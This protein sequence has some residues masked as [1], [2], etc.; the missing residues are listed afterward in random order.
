MN[1]SRTLSV[2]FCLTTAVLPAAEPV[3]PAEREFFEKSV[4]PVLATHCYQC[5]GPKKQ[6]AELRLDSR[7]GMLKGG[8][9]GPAITPGKPED[10]E[11][12]LA[13][14]Y[15]PSGYQMPPTGKLKPDEIEALTRWVKMGAPW[16]GDAETPA[17]G[18]E[19]EG[20]DIAERARHWSFQPVRRPEVPAVD[21]TSWPRNPIDQFLLARLEA[22]S[23]QPADPAGKRTWLRRVTFDLTGLPPTPEE[24][25]RFLEDHSPEAHEKVVDRLLTSPAYGERWARHWLDLVR[26]AE[27]SGHEFDYDIEYSRPYRDYVVR[28]LNADVPYN[29]F[30]IEHIAGDLLPDP[31]RHPL[32]GTNESIIG[33]GFYWFGQGKHS[34]VD[35]A[36]EE[37]D[38][39][40]N[41]LDVLGKTFLGLTIACA[42]CHDH[43]FDPITARDYYAMS[44][45]LQSSRRQHAYIDPPERTKPLLQQLADVQEQRSRLLS[46]ILAREIKD[47]DAVLDAANESAA[48]DLHHPLHAW[49]V[50]SRIDSESEFLAAKNQLIEK[51]S[52]LATPDSV[53]VFA[54]FSA[55]SLKQWRRTGDAFSEAFSPASEPAADA[56]I[57]KLSLPMTANSGTL[58]GRLQGEL[59]SP[60]FAIAKRY[61]DYR[62][63]RIGGRPNPGRPTKNGQVHLIVDGFQFIKDPLYGQLTINIPPNEPFRW[64][65]QDL[66]KFQGKNAYIEIED[67]EDGAVI[68]DRI[69][70]SDA[71]PPPEQA[72]GLV[73]SLLKDPGLTNPDELRTGYANLFRESV[74]HWQEDRLGNDDRS[75]SRVELLNAVLTAISIRERMTAEE[76]SEFESLTNKLAKRNAEIPEP[77]R[78][79]AMADGTG[80]EARVLIRG[81]PSKPGD[82]VSRRF[83]EVFHDPE[84][85]LPAQ[86]S[87][88]LELARQIADGENPLTA[89]VLVNRLWLHHFGRGLVATPDDF[90]KMGEAPSHPELL[91][92]L[93]SEF[94][95]NGWSLKHMHRLMVL[96]Q[97]YRMVS[98]AHAGDEADPKNLLLHRMPVRRLEAE[99]IRDAVLAVS[100]RLDRRMEGPSVLPHLTPFMEGRG[101]PG[102]SGPLDGDGRRSLYI[103]VRRNFLT[104]MFLAFDYP[105]PFTTMGRRSVSNVPAQALTM[106]NNPFIIQQARVWADRVLA[107]KHSD[108]ESRIQRLYEMAYTRP[109]TEAEVKSAVEFLKIQGQEYNGPEDPRTWADLCHVLMNV[110]E[111]LFVN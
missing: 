100:G 78:A 9:T 16:P 55:E 23:L 86:G 54:D 10:S 81:N 14:S 39:I 43:K 58:A 102:R 12:V 17:A 74:K 110:K 71:G 60:T 41:Q 36:A 40:D 85:S 97:T 19:S 64:Y 87:G 98:R 35:L 61:I 108:A 92:W 65:R 79:I 37:C 62:M 109:P 24:A 18:G 103:N 11:L 75:R 32:T 47:L 7:A 104:P 45:F 63:R 33:T 68:V 28:A 80:E 107:E 84:H 29:Q 52:A 94:V 51:L 67:E 27:T 69:V 93:A 38:S 44:G 22:A 76:R 3:T 111:F 34:P 56:G 8:Q 82:K 31:R 53:E 101:R 2:F 70:F 89:R 5:H 4:R 73:L 42:R 50:L 99:A 25:E 49:A 48:K 57:V 46:R 26:F 59:R 95:D 13:I 15:D 88:R 96:S 21:N 91:D 66:E 77:R 90:G 83:L 106:M 72:N 30:V 105:T 6:E 20:I 1:R